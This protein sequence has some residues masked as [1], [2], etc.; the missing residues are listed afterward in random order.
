MAGQDG[1]LQLGHH[2]LLEAEHAG[3]ERA[4]GGDELGRVAPHLLGHR[5][6]FPA[7]GAQVGDRPG[8]SA[9]GC[10]SPGAG[11]RRGRRGERGRPWTK[12][13]PQPEK[14]RT[15]GSEP[16][17][18][19]APAAARPG[20]GAGRASARS[21]RWARA[22]G[23]AQRRRRERDADER[24]VGRQ[25][26]GGHDGGTEP[27]GH[28]GEDAGHL[29][30]L[31]DQMRLHPGLGARRQG[32][33]AQVVAL[34][35]HHQVEPVEIAHADAAATGEGVIGRGGEHERVVEERRGH[36]QRVG[37]REHDQGQVDLARPPPGAPAGAS[38]PPP[39]TGRCRGGWR[40]R[41]RGRA[42]ARS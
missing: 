3:H 6:R 39:R 23:A 7:R 5:H 13:K 42:P 12:P 10:G 38:P 20:R 34:P 40:G 32:H 28:E 21:P 2:G 19:G 25:R 16:E 27:G 18:A 4:A 9:G 8:R 15:S 30:T 29:A 1:V 24:T 36:H 33:G 37:H 14:R 35:E 26:D 41:P 17:A 11:W 22:D 31:A